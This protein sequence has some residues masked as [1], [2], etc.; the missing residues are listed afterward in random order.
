MLKRSVL[1]GFVLAGFASGAFAQS[2]APQAR[3]AAQL[4]ML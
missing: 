3:P 4:P 2:P 1:A